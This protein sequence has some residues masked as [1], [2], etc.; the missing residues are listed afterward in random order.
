M[1]GTKQNFRVLLFNML[2]MVGPWISVTFSVITINYESVLYC[3]TQYYRGLK[4]PSTFRRLSIGVGSVRQNP[5][6]FPKVRTTNTD[7]YKVPA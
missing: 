7:S 4:I 5:E 3:N 2:N 6:H 1:K